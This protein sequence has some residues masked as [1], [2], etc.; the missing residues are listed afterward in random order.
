MN[1]VAVLLIKKKNL[2]LIF[3][4]PSKASQMKTEVYKLKLRYCFLRKHF[5]CFEV[6][7]LK[8]L[9]SFEF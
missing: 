4:I 8:Y 3:F 5:F 1:C 2:S 7:N 9:T 6:T